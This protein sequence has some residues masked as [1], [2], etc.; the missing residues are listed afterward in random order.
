MV[1]GT[2]SSLL[3]DKGAE[4]DY[5]N[6]F[7]TDGTNEL[8]V[9]GCYPGWGA[10][11]DDRKFLVADNGL[12]VGDEITM[13]GYKDTYKGVVELCKTACFSFKKAE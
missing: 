3:D 6:M 7:I 1:T 5:G 9:Y 12:E 10:T 8:Y 11:G 13:I 2:I 4:N